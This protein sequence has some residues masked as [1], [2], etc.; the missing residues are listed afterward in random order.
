MTRIE[1]LE[2]VR[3]ETYT[4]DMDLLKYLSYDPIAKRYI[5]HLLD[6]P[7]FNNDLFR[8]SSD[9]DITYVSDLIFKY[10]NRN[11]NISNL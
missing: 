7:Y 8:N 2:Y 3:V 10:K 6:L 4:T 5:S 9:E 1:R 11:C